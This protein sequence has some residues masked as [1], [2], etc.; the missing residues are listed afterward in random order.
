MG[1]QRPIQLHWVGSLCFSLCMPALAQPVIVT[2]EVVV[3]AA[4]ISQPAS[5]ALQ[6]VTVISA[7]DI[8]AAG[9][10]TLAELLQAKGGVEITSNGGPGQSSAV[11]I[12]GAE[13]THTL[14][15]IDGV[16][17]NSAT[18]G[19]T[20]LEHIPLSQIE[21]V[22]IVAGPLSSLYGSEAIGGVIQVFTRGSRAAPG[23][24]GSVSYGAYNTHNVSGGFG[25][26]HHD[27][28]FNINAALS[29]AG[30][31][32]TT[33]ASIPFGQH[34]PDRDGYRN[35]SVSAKIAHHFGDNHELG[36][37]LFQAEGAAHFD[38]GPATDDVNRTTV[39]ASSI[40][41]RNRITQNWQ[42]LLKLGFGLD[43]SV[44]VG[45][46]PS[47]TRTDQTQFSWQNDVKLGV[48]SLIGGI[49]HLDQHV[50]STTAYNQTKRTVDSLFAGYLGEWG[51]HSWQLN[52]RNDDNSQFGGRTTGSLGYG[53]RINSNVRVRFGAGTAFKAPTFNDLY[54]QDPFFAG[55]PNL[56]PERS[57]SREAGIDLT[58]QYGKFSAVWFENR[59]SDLIV[60]DPATFATMINLSQTRTQG[61]EFGYS[62]EVRGY[63]LRAKATLQNPV[64]EANNTLLPRRAKQFGSAA[65]SHAIGAWRGGAEVVASGA[66]FNGSNEV[67]T[68]RMHGYGL[69]NLFG[70]YRIDRKWSVDARWNNALGRDYELVQNFNTPGSNLFVTLRYQP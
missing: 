17:A 6:P 39:N 32:S 66:R 15:L 68:Q 56:R 49:E 54:F 53:H 59:I 41:S 40:Y 5:R 45:A 16:R 2:D 12:R 69:L 52:A 10:Q 11:R 43:D 47:R 58:G 3:T 22:E 26:W 29:D 50:T 34:N 25:A 14:V 33:K 60:I 57:R 48:G 36:A 31:F 44:I 42:S 70:S 63:Q 23:A 30:G 38:A 24:T 65:V 9:Q 27:T 64:N 18:A 4:R 7:E 28:E 62:T 37:T 55:N 8:A 21:R 67:P 51:Q 61:T 46:F 19:T 35:N 20:S 1:N 13:S